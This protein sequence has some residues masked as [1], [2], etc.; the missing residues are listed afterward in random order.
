M[1]TFKAVR[2]AA[3]AIIAFV[4]KVAFSS[5]HN[6]AAPDF[7]RPHQERPIRRNPQGKWAGSSGFS[8]S[9]VRKDRLIPGSKCP[10]HGPIAALLQQGPVISDKTFSGP[11]I[12]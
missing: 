12:R 3:P 6:R 1:T 2:Y 4:S 9:T 7:L 11:S 8:G 5:F 10:D